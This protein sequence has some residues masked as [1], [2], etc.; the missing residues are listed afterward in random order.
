M[1]NGADTVGPL[2]KEDCLPGAK[3][4]QPGNEAGQRP[5]TWMEPKVSWWLCS[6]NS[7]LERGTFQD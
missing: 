1:L 7:P 2:R 5:R 6:K 4:G 3:R